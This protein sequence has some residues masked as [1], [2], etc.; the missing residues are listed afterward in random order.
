MTSTSP[1]PIC[2]VPALGDVT[3]EGLRNNLRV[4]VQYI[5]AWLR[6][7]GCVPLYNLMEDAATAEIC[8]SQVWQWL[9]HRS[10]LA[11]GRAITEALVGELLDDEMATLKAALG[12]RYAE[13]RFKDA[14]KLFLEVATPPE[15]VNFLT[16]PA[17][18]RLTA[19]AAAR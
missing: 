4:G 12:K 16:L 15:F 13:G 10:R 14:V 3:E 8:R 18:A 17:Y 6:G 2:C 11:D 19:E 1:P 5:E 7:Q 9:K